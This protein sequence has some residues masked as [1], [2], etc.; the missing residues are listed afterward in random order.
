LPI[1]ILNG[2]GGGSRTHTE[3]PPP[4]FESGASANSTTPA[5]I[6]FKGFSASSAILHFEGP[7]KFQQKKSEHIENT[8]GFA[9]F[10]CDCHYFTCQTMSVEILII[11]SS[12]RG[13]LASPYPRK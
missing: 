2:A 8:E 7:A 12:K 11:S 10:I 13:T 3:L 5:T 9:S 6:D 1:P 4:D